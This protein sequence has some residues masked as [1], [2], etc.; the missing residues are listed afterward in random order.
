MSQTNEELTFEEAFA[1]LEDIVAQLESGE[2]SLAAS[3][4]LYE[5]G[6][7][8]ARLCGDMLDT[9]ELRVQ[10]ISNEGTLGALDG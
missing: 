9:A 2:L 7:T 4:D 6:Q 5:R 3:V 8:L 1:Q 10:Q